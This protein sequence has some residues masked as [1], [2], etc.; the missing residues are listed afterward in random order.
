MSARAA[1]QPRMLTKEQAAAYC[2]VS[3]PTFIDICPLPPV[4]L[5]PDARL[6]RWDVRA[7]DEW[8]DKIAGT[9][10]PAARP[11]SMEWKSIDSAP[12]DGTLFL[13]ANHFSGIRQVT[14]FG[15]TS[16]VPL[17]GWAFNE[18]GDPEDTDLW[19]PTHWMP[20]PDAPVAI[21]KDTADVG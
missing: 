2:G 16:H 18:T 10:S 15:K 21:T 4:S 8:L 5:G 11:T 14:W 6:N 9:G 20:L 3:V 7:L 17:Y 1:I 19:S 12:L 13:A